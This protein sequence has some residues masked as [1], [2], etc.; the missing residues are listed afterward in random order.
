MPESAGSSP[1]EAPA[2]VAKSGS[3]AVPWR[4][5]LLVLSFAPLFLALGFLQIVISV[6]F[7]TAGFTVAQAGTIIAVQGLVL[8]LVSI[9][10]GILSDRYG[11]KY[12]LILGVTAG[13]M[14]L[15]VFALTTDYV[16]LLGVSVIL[17]ITEAAAITT[18]NALLADLTE[19]PNR[20]KVFSLS[21]VVLN[22]SSGVG[23]AT[24]A[25]FPTLQALFS[26]TNY[27]LHRDTL[28]VFAVVSFL[29]PA[30]VF[31]LLRGHKE[32][33][34]PRR[35]LGGLKNASTM[36]KFA[37]VGGTIGFGAGFIIPLIGSWFYLRFYVGDDVSG[38]IMALS[39]ILI[40]FS[41]VA[42]PRLAQRFGRMKAIMLTTGSSMVFMLSMAFIPAFELAAGV[43]IIRSALMNMA[44]PLL[45][46]FSMSIFPAEQRGIVS[47]LGNISFR[48][49]NS[50]STYMG[51]VIL[52]LGL[53]QLPF[54]IAS[55]LYIVG[56]TAFYLFFVASGKYE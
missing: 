19:A 27:S 25:L 1:P 12:L 22:V 49:P 35:G 21:F 13:S 55:G 50:I 39:N 7:V 33:L 44:G 34:G 51:G 36:A 15:T 42:S 40:G 54:F 5:A 31:I 26:V 43:F 3:T 32:T 45:D 4:I 46:S 8:I 38:P 30:M 56:L 9:P 17:G 24:P 20:N 47:A 52:G 11:R 29:T 2:V 10:L 14:A 23:L 48:L 37:V 16:I 6:W 28:L 18:W 41:A 53:L